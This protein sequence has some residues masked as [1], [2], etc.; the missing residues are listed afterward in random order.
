[1]MPPIQQIKFEMAL[2]TF[3]AL[4]DWELIVEAV[5]QSGRHRHWAND[6]SIRLCKILLISIPWKLHT[7]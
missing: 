6:H 7:I 1:M 4:F 5:H 3:M 2:T